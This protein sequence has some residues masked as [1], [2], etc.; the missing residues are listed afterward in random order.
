[1]LNLLNIIL[2]SKVNKIEKLMDENC[3]EIKRHILISM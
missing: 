1:M 3:I 2:F